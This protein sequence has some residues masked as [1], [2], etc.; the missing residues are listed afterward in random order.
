MTDCSFRVETG[1]HMTVDKFAGT[2]AEAYLLETLNTYSI[3]ETT[4]G[5]D[6]GLE[7]R[8]IW[9]DSREST[10]YTTIAAFLWRYLS[11]DDRLPLE[12]I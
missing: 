3:S 6:L 9:E 7:R 8:K 11:L 2:S 4:R 12:Y 1:R 10:R 5:N